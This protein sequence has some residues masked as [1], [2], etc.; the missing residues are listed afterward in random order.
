M[1]LSVGFDLQNFTSREID[2]FDGL[3]QLVTRETYSPSVF[4]EGRRFI[5]NFDS[6]DLIALDFDG[7]LTLDAARVRF[8]E[9]RCIIGTTKSHG[10]EKHGVVSDRFRVILFLSKSITDVETY[11]ATIIDLMNRFPEADPACKDPA[12]LFFKCVSIVYTNESGKLIDPVKPVPKPPVTA[13]VIPSGVVGQLS[14]KTL[15]FIALGAKPGTWNA[16]LFQAAKDCQEQGYSQKE[17][18]NVLLA[19]TRKELGNDGEFDNE[20]LGTIT[21]AYNSDAK[22]APRLEKKAFNFR[23]IEDLYR[24]KPVV[25][26]LVDGVLTVGGISIIAG[27]PKA[28]KSTLI[29]N[30]TK[31]VAKGDKFLGRDVKAGPVIYFALEEQEEMLYSQFK[32]IGVTEND[33]VM[34]HVGT[35]GTQ[36]WNEEFEEFIMDTRPSLVVLDTLV[37]FANIQDHNNY[38]EVYRAITRYCDIA[39]RSKTHILCIHHTNKSAESDRKGVNLSGIQTI[40]G[41]SAFAGAVDT[42]IYFIREGGSRYITTD[43]RGG[44]P[45]DKHELIFDPQTQIYTIGESHGF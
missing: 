11:Y 20:D 16:R 9:Y 29:R 43:Q 35:P 3:A 41:S 23:T 22:Y 8:A 36:D 30:L 17:A 42:V 15:D 19:A 33:P 37:K 18:E 28:G 27:P 26:W 5:K 45:F 14:K 32:K 12:R 21:S 40:M 34:F 31:A 44:T 7:G 25:E 38:R 13:P 4:R 39:R 6:A 2:S 1:K 24:T 10:K